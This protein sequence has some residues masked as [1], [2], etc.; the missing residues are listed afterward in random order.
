MIDYI[1]IAD[2]AIRIKAYFKALGRTMTPEAVCRLTKKKDGINIDI[3]LIEMETDLGTDVYK[4][5]YSYI[6]RQHIVQ[7]NRRLGA[8]R[9][10]VIYHEVGHRVLHWKSTDFVFH[11]DSDM[12]GVKTTFEVEANVFSAEMLLDDDRVLSCFFRK[13]YTFFQTAQALGVP[14]E[15]LYFKCKILQARGHKINIPITVTGNFMKG[16]LY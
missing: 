10:A 9:D 3:E 15:I 5:N 8:Y 7:F 16:K 13:G 12:Y 6:K 14:D 4:G 1:G 11:I 2:E